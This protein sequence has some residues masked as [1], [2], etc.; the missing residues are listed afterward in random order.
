MRIPLKRRPKDVRRLTDPDAY[1][2]SGSPGLTTVN[3][4][5]GKVRRI[6]WQDERHDQ[7]RKVRTVRI[8]RK[9][10]KFA[11]KIGIPL[12]MLEVGLT[13]RD[14]YQAEKLKAM[15]VKKPRIAAKLAEE[16]KG[17]RV[18]TFFSEAAEAA[19]AFQAKERGRPAIEKIAERK[20]DLQKADSQ[21]KERGRRIEAERQATVRSSERMRKAEQL[22]DR[23]YD[24]VSGRRRRKKD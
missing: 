15:L 17:S 16:F 18:E 13:M 21:F 4:F 10:L 6:A 14:L 7:E 1:T 3:K 12:G 2:A 11:T 23:V 19:R 8:G 9:E 20:R 24:A 22:F 5:L